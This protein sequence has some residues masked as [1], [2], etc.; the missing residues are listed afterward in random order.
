MKTAMKIILFLEIMSDRKYLKLRSPL[1]DIFFSHFFPIPPMYYFFSTHQGQGFSQ[2][3]LYLCT[4][5]FAQPTVRAQLLQSVLAALFPPLP[6]LPR[7]LSPNP[8]QLLLPILH[9]LLLF[10][11]QLLLFQLLLHLHHHLL[12]RITT[13][14]KPLLLLLFAGELD[15]H[16]R[17]RP[18]L[19]LCR[20][21]FS[22][23]SLFLAFS[24]LIQP[25]DF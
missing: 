24:I 18:L 10:P 20:G 1:S 19:P 4:T 25:P 12:L 2:Y 16:Q 13:S 5:Y 14:S 11:L 21:E 8:L 9:H 6:P 23:S 15:R 22:F 17:V 3:F 7:R